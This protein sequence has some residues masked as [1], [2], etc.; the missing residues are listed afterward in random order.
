MAE[1]VPSGLL[2][3]S[4]VNGSLRFERAANL[5]KFLCQ[6]SLRENGSEEKKTSFFLPSFL[7]FI[8]SSSPSFFFPSKKFLL[9]ELF[10]PIVH[11]LDF[12]WKISA[13]SVFEYWKRVVERIKRH[14]MPPSPLHPLSPTPNRYENW[15][16]RRSSSCR[17]AWHACRQR[18]REKQKNARDKGPGERSYKEIRK[19]IEGRGSG[20]GRNGAAGTEQGTKKLD[21]DARARIEKRKEIH[22]ATN[23]TERASERESERRERWR[24]RDERGTRLVARGVKKSREVKEEVEKRRRKPALPHKNITVNDYQ[25]LFSSRALVILCPRRARKFRNKRRVEGAAWLADRSAT[26]LSDWPAGPHPSCNGRFVV[27]RRRYSLPLSLSLSL[28]P[29]PSR[30]ERNNVPTKLL[31]LLFEKISFEN[32]TRKRVFIQASAY[33]EDDRANRKIYLSSCFLS[34]HTPFQGIVDL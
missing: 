22:A 27:S 6:N 2:F 34:M 30:R 32:E 28:S 15:P 33:V 20:C 26:R 25:P 29:L 5:S 12:R 8:L 31:P 19:E 3:L 4:T 1:A 9:R 17:F 16:A 24:D 23:W 14:E 7:S 21:G 18:A 13:D 10:I 11:E